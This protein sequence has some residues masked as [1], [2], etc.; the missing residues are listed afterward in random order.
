MLWRVNTKRIKLINIYFS[1][2]TSIF[3]F[4]RQIAQMSTL[5]MTHLGLPYRHGGWKAVVCAETRA[6]FAHPRFFLPSAAPQPIRR[7]AIR[8]MKSHV[9]CLDD[10]LVDYVIRAKLLEISISV[11]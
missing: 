8:L 4:E 3:I 2:S 6:L 10:F 11:T 5:V 7:I 9:L 1:V